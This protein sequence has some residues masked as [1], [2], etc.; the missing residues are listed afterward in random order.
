MKTT[1]TP[2]YAVRNGVVRDLL[3]GRVAEQV[4]A[5]DPL[6]A[7]FARLAVE[8]GDKVSTAVD[9]PD[10]SPDRTTAA[11]VLTARIIRAL[12]AADDQFPLVRR[13]RTSRIDQGLLLLSGE[14]EVKHPPIVMAVLKRIGQHRLHRQLDVS[15]PKR[16]SVVFTWPEPSDEVPVPVPEA[17]VELWAP[18]VAEEV[19][20]A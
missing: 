13:W 8:H 15:D 10:W 2:R 1:T 11:E 14:L 4:H 16:L 9:Y 3:A 17:V 7:A 18:A 6:D 12:A 19:R 20:A 5:V